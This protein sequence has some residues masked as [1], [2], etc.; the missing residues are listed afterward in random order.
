[1]HII[2]DPFKV[3]EG[4]CEPQVE[5]YYDEV[6]VKTSGHL[7]CMQPYTTLATDEKAEVCEA[8]IAHMCKMLGVEDYLARQMK[9]AYRGQVHV[10]NPRIPPLEPDLVYYTVAYGSLSDGITFFGPFTQD[11][12]GRF[13]EHISGTGFDSQVIPLTEARIMNKTHGFFPMGP[14]GYEVPA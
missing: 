5:R 9:E 1:M 8:Y 7:F 12:A 4:E 6:F 10:T 2:F 11:N 14:N 13:A 3:R